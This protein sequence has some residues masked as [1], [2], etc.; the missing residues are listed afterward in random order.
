MTDLDV[1]VVGLGL[2]G[3]AISQRLLASTSGFSVHGFDL[4]PE[5]GERLEQFGGVALN[6]VHDVFKT[7]RI[8]MLSLPS[9]QIVAKLLAETPIPAGRIVIDTTTGDPDHAIQ[10]AETML[11]ATGQ[12]I[13]ANVAGSSVQASRGEAVVFVGSDEDPLDTAVV[14]VLDAIT[15]RRYHVGPVGAASRFKLVHNLLLGLH[16]AVLAEG[17]NF[18]R[19]LGFDEGETLEILQATP[20]ASAVMPTKGPKMVDRDFAPQATLSQ[21]L[22]DVR[23]IV[24]LAQK[25]GVPSPLSE[26]HQQLLEQA[27]SLGWGKDDNSAVIQAFRGEARS[28]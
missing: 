13:E 17:L 4:R 18:A 24:N 22:K 26:R 20:A 2:L 19:A 8:V 6:S 15:T 23:L 3:S 12:Y 10:H 1:G 7:C 14:A 16:R 21:H 5:C 27:E 28:K 11:N 25:R 9:S